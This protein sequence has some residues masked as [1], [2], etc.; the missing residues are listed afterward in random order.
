MIESIK[1]SYLAEKLATQCLKINVL[2]F[3]PIK[4]LDIINSK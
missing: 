4:S 2:Y 3:I 1:T